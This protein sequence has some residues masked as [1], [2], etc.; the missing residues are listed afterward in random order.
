MECCR[1]SE[2]MSNAIMRKLD[3]KKLLTEALDR[4]Q[5]MALA[6]SGDEG[7]WVCPVYFAFDERFRLYFISQPDSKHMKNIARNPAVAVAIFSTDQEPRRDVVGVQLEGMAEAVPKEDAEEAH[8]IYFTETEAR[9]PVAADHP[10]DHY[11]SGA[12]DWRI[13]RIIP[14][15]IYYFDTEFFDADVPGSAVEIGTVSQLRMGLHDRSMAHPRIEPDVQNIFLFG[16][17]LTAT[18]CAF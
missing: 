17:L 13:M 4:T 5:F 10:P 14:G 8:R 18:A 6:T 9:R 15:R 7:V 11:V 2:Q 1:E 16:E 12:A 3:W